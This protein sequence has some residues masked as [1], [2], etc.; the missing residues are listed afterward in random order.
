MNSFS[1]RT[2][3]SPFASETARKRNGTLTATSAPASTS[4]PVTGVS[5][6]SAGGSSSSVTVARSPAPM[7]GIAS[8]EAAR[9]QGRPAGSWS[10]SGPV[11]APPVFATSKETRRRSPRSIPVSRKPGFAVS[12]ATSGTTETRS[13]TVVA[14]PSAE[15]TRR[16]S[17]PV[18]CPASAVA[19]SV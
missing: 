1:T 13:A 15:V 3:T 11:S 18:A 9:S 17:V 7:L 16:P 2:T 8:G 5:A 4:A 10:C 14:A 19:A 12:T 6:M